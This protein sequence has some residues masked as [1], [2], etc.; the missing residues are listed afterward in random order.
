MNVQLANDNEYKDTND[1]N[2]EINEIDENYDNLPFG[3]G[4]K[5]GFCLFI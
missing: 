5:L 4:N 1:T 3:A 2:N